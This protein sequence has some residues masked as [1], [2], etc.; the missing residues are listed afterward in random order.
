MSEEEQQPQLYKP[1]QV[2]LRAADTAAIMEALQMEIRLV[3]R[4]GAFEKGHYEWLW[5][6]LAH[7]TEVSVTLEQ[8]AFVR[9]GAGAKDA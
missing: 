4:P 3:N 5:N 9:I 8:A 1:A 2:V 6:L 7:S